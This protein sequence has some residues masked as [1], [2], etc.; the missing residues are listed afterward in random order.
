MGSPSLALLALLAA[1][2]PSAGVQQAAEL[3]A[4][5]E[6]RALIS[7]PFLEE[8]TAAFEERHGV[9]VR[10]VDLGGAAGTKDRL[11]FLLA[12]DVPLDLVRVD[13]TEIAAY[14]ADDAL[15]NLQTHFNG[16][17]EWNEED[18]FRAPLDALRGPDGGLLGLPQTFTPYVMY[19]NLDRFAELEIARPEP[20]WTWDDLLQ[21]ARAATEDV[22]GDGRTDLWGIS[23]TQWL[24]AITPWIWQAGGDILTVDEETGAARAAMESPGFIRAL[25]F[26]HQLLHVERVASNDATFAAQMEQGLFQAGRAAMYGPVG[27]W[28]TYRFR[29]LPFRWDVVPLP[30]DVTEA[31]AVAMSCYVVPRTSRDPA[32]AYLFLREVLGSD[33]YQRRMAEI[34]NGVP[35]LV[36]AAHSESFLDPNRPPESE[37]VF[38]DVMANARFLPTSANWAKIESLCT[39][40]LEG[41]L[42]SG[43]LAP[44]DAARAMARKTDAYLAR[45]AQRDDRARLHPLVLPGAVVAAIL[46]FLGLV[47]LPRRPRGAGAAREERSA[48]LMLVPWAIGF[49]AFL[50]GPAVVSLAL[51]FTEWSPLRPLSDARYAGL[52]QWQRL[53]VDPT[54]MTSLRATLLYMA[55][56]VPLQLIL[57]LLLALGLR[58]ASRAGGVVRTLCY[59][60][61]VVSPVVVA[62][63]WRTLLRA[64]DGPLNDLLSHVGIS[65]PAWLTDANW[66][67][68]SFV[69]LAMWTCGAQMLVFLAALQSVDAELEEAARIDGAGP[70]ARVWHVVLPALAPVIFFNL[71]TGMIAAAQ[72]FAQPYVM[73]GGGP[74]DASRFLVLYLYEA[75]FRH[76][77]MGYASAIAWVLVLVLGALTIALVLGTRILVPRALGLDG[78]DR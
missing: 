56:A 26:L 1:H 45:V 48:W 72:V 69:L 25:E 20:G 11:K 9:K 55:M 19:L 33:A 60:P 39:P 8:L 78:A 38:L 2:G 24:Q 71:V 16:D 10:L 4:M 27:Y 59:V 51:S 3:V 18:W 5:V 74:G 57:A 14:V 22:D 43:R 61:T 70:I 21:I 36:S 62:A 63:I 34:G 58:R 52:D 54:F 23:V 17:A 53:A 41:V 73:T 76:L 75:G 13:V 29:T 35:G 64:D 42:L 68:P 37:Q 31:T 77:E 40:E 47:L 65:G 50:L 66:V 28:E 32:L 67:V 49:V 44:R 15:V 30:G 6:D 7:W 12:G 46:G